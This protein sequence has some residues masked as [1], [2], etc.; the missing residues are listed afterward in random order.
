MDYPYA[1]RRE[2]WRGCQSAETKGKS[3]GSSHANRA[4]GELWTGV[5]CYALSLNTHGQKSITGHRVGIN[6]SER[7]SISPLFNTGYGP[8]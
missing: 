8:L 3:S 1:S 5:L 2:P 4:K 6:V 7:G